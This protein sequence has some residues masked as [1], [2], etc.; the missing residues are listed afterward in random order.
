M[1]NGFNRIRVTGPALNVAFWKA[2]MEVVCG[3]APCCPSC[4]S[5][6]VRAYA[7]NFN[8][9]KSG[10]WIWCNHCNQWS[11]ASNMRINVDFADRYKDATPEEFEYMERNNWLDRL[12]QDWIDGYR[13]SRKG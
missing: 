10:L 5:P 8:E 11:V 6:E 3:S 1:V 7:H 2:G 9:E 12:E 13:P 4:A